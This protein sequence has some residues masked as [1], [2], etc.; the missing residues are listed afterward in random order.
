MA[1]IVLGFCLERVKIIWPYLALAHLILISFLVTFIMYT[2]ADD[3]IYSK[4][5][6]QPVGM[7]I[8]FIGISAVS[9]SSL[10]VN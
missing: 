7:T 1:G 10:V 4:A 2:P 6:P 9:I 5:N 3:H 8:G